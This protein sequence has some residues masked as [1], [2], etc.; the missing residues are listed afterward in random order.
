MATLYS[1]QWHRARA[2]YMRTLPGP[3]AKRAAELGELV[4]R[5]IER[6][7]QENRARSAELVEVAGPPLVPEN[8]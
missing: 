8:S 7:D 5:L 2:A 1:A 6:K 3:K 4:A